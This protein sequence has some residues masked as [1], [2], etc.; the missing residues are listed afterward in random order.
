MAYGK[1]YT[2]TQKTHDCVDLTVDIYEKDYTGAVTSYQAVSVVLQPNS[3]EEDPI[4]TIISSELNVSFTISTEEDYANFLDL[5]D[6]DDTKYYVELLISGVVKWKGFLFNDYA[7][8][9]FTG[10]TQQV[11]INAIDGLSLLRYSFFDGFE[12]TNDNVRL[13]D[14][15][16]TCLNKLQYKDTSF[17]YSL[18]SYYAEGMFDRGDA[19]GDEPFIQTYQFRRDF[20]GLDYYTVLSN[21]VKSFG[22][23]LFQANGDWYIL[24]MNQMATTLYYT[25]YVVEDI[26]TVSGTGIFVNNITIQPYTENNIHFIGGDQVKIVKKGYPTIEAEIPFSGATNYIY[27]GAFKNVDLITDVAQGWWVTKIGGA[28]VDFIESSSA[29]LNICLMF[30]GP[31]KEARLSNKFPGPTGIYEFTPKMYGPGASLSFEL[32]E[33]TIRVYIT[34]LVGST[35]YYLNTDDKWQTTE[36]FRNVSSTDYN[37]FTTQSIN[38]PLGFQADL[39]LMIEGYVNVEFRAVD[40]APGGYLRNI[41]M[42]QNSPAIEAVVITRKIE[43]TDAVGKSIDLPYGIVY[44][45]SNT[46]NN[47]YNNVGLFVDEDR[48]PLINWYSYSYPATTYE[49]LPYLIMRQ[50]SN[51]LN[52]NIATLEGNLGNYESTAGLVYLDKVFLVEDSTTGAMTYNG[53]KFLMNRMDLDAANVQIGSIQLVEITNTNNASVQTVEYIGDIQIVKPKRYFK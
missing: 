38:V 26:P 10:G 28:N 33:C 13:L 32:Q 30:A 11:A 7:E 12:N 48:N 21:I 44:N 46:S 53:K 18:C 40:G 8:V 16:G 51:L 37:V 5:L 29:Q 23:R 17:F 45:P 50:Y 9:G 2:I 34:C 1:K 43:E 27:N 31:G 6:Y 24:P 35:T 39:S 52:R 19:V 41:K 3:S 25:R 36:T 22:C 42:T 20:V 4:G 15:I 47:L 14:I 49:S